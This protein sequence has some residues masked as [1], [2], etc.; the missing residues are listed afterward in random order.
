[1]KTV[2]FAIA[3][4]LAAGGLVLYAP[5]PAAWACSCVQMTDRQAL[6]E[7]DAAFV[8]RPQDDPDKP[9]PFSSTATPWRWEFVVDAVIKGDLGSKVTV[10]AAREE[11]S[12]GIEFHPGRRYLVFAYVDDNGDYQTNLCQRTRPLAE[13]A[14]VPLKA[15]EPPAHAQNED[16]GNSERDSGFELGLIG[17]LST[18]AV[19][20][21]GAALIARRR[22][23]Q[24][25]VR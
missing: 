7:S 17:F 20:A 12:C 8:G 5:A 13:G 19:A 6:H 11:A 1:M 3:L 10:A 2:R 14:T 25:A 21:G 4:A 9:D 22:R 18:G 23:S 15:H 16:P 24:R